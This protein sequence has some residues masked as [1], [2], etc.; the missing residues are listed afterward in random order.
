TISRFAFARVGAP[1]HST[2]SVL[3]ARVGRLRF[4]TED[5]FP[6]PYLLLRARIDSR[7]RQWVQLRVPGRPNGRTGWVVRGALARFHIAHEHL[8]I[9]RTT[10]LAVLYRNGTPIWRSRIGVGTPS[11]PTPAGHYIVRERFSIAKRGGIYGPYAFGTS[12]YSVLSDWPRGGVVGV[13]GTNAPGLI[14][15]RPSHGCVRV[16][17]AAILRLSRL[18]PVGTSVEII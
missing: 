9:N 7:G 3:G 10:L 12:A 15:G 1:V 2:P 8:R 6:E 13:H 5:G 4:Q 11:T 17:N 14:P 16:P 18:M